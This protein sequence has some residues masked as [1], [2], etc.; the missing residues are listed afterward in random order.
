MLREELGSSARTR[1]GYM[2]AKPAFAGLR[3]RTDYREYGA[4]PLLGVEAGCFIGHGRSNA[5]AIHSSIRRA[6]E[7]VA[8]DLAAK[9]RDKVA[10][11]HSEELR[12]LGK[13]GAGAVP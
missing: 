8:A 3:R 4:A 2:L 11:L 5:R 1:I 6:V 7:F 10:E 9:I 12:L 13:A